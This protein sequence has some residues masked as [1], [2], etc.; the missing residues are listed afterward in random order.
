MWRLLY[1]FLLFVRVYF[2]LC[3]SYLHPD[4]IFQGPEPLAGMLEALHSV[5]HLIDMSRL[6]FP[7]SKP[8]NMGMDVFP[9]NSQRFPAMANLRTADDIVEMDMGSR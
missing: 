7:L 6:S 2:A 1:L 5:L 4:E 3:P 8:P 9:P